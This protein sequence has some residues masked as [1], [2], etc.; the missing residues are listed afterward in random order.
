MAQTLDHHPRFAHRDA[1]TE[2]LFDELIHAADPA[3]A[4]RTM[5]RIALLYLDLCETM[6][7]RYAGRGIDHDDLVQV[8]RLAL[9]KAIRRYRPGG[10]PSFAAYAVPTV[11]GE[12][13]RHFRDRGWMV[14]PP[15]RVQE[16]RA[17]LSAE[18]GGRWR[19]DQARQWRRVEPPHAARGDA[20]AAQRE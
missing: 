18:R 14:R 6:A 13:K 20:E 12:L 17:N 15:R 19:G 1:C 5:E 8:A 2:D 4:A 3:S 16:L 9:V 11:S 10:G 7:G